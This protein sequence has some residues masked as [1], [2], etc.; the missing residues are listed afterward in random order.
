MPL[1]ITT[2]T[3]WTYS[4]YAEGFYSQGRVANAQRKFAPYIFTYPDNRMV[5]LNHA[6]V[7]IKIKSGDLFGI[8]GIHTGRYVDENYAAEP[9][10]LRPI[11]SLSVGAELL[12]EW[13]IEGGVF[14]SHIGFESAIGKDGPTLTRALISDNSPYFESGIRVTYSETPTLSITGLILNGWQVMSDPNSS[15][16]VGTQI[17][18]KLS[19]D[20]LINSSSFMGNEQ[21][22]GAMPKIRYF[23]DLYSIITVE[24]RLTLIPAADIGVQENGLGG[25]ASWGGAALVAAYRWTPSIRTGAR[26]E[27]FSDPTGVVVTGVESVKR[28]SI[29]FDSDLASGLRWRNELSWTW[30]SVDPD[31]RI[32]TALSTAFS[33]NGELK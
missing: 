3:S 7:E 31:V 4:G 30:G 16:A 24:D 8:A 28:A 22:D 12:P 20:V 29:N 11:Y 6:A 17:Q 2:S 26:V 15:K 14:A 21:S 32:T 18:Y 23:H 5:D 33:G 9:S 1:A 27:F 13:T 25:W 10:G 19:P